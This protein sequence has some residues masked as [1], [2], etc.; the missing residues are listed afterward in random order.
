MA[1]WSDVELLTNEDTNT[2]RLDSVSGEENGSGLYQV[3]TLVKISSADKVPAD[4]RLL[5]FGASNW[6]IVVIDKTVIL[7]D[8]SY[9]TILLL[10]HF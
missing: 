4:P 1:T 2:V 6:S 8:Q 9:Q 7:F 10:L 3:D 5:S